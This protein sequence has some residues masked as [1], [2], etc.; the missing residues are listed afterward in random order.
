VGRYLDRIYKILKINDWGL[1]LE[2]EPQMKT[3][4]DRLRRG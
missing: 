4:R 1:G 2:E 3:D